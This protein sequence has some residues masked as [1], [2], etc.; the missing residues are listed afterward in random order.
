MNKAH[1]R[2]NLANN[3]RALTYMFVGPK[4][5]HETFNEII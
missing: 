3:E 1:R 4:S 2:E 5:L